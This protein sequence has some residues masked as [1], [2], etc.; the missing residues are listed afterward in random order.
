MLKRLHDI[1]DRRK[2]TIDFEG[3]QLEVP[4]GETVSAAVLAAETDYTRTSAIS[5][6]HRGP[7]CQMGVCFECLMEI[8]GVP[9]SQACMIEVRHGMTVRRQHGARG[10]SD[11]ASV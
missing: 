6:V 2:V 11:E 9:N 5:G 4:A 7:Y 8:D 1:S 3:M 10:V